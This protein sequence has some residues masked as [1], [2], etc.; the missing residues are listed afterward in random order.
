M[1]S[2][3]TSVNKLAANS[4]NMNLEPGDT[5][6]VV[7]AH[8]VPMVL[9]IIKTDPMAAKMAKVIFLNQDIHLNLRTATYQARWAEIRPGRPQV[10]E[11]SVQRDVEVEVQARL[12]RLRIDRSRRDHDWS[13]RHDDRRALVDDAPR[14]LD[15]APVLALFDI[16]AVFAAPVLVTPVIVVVG[17]GT[18]RKE[19][20]GT[21]DRGGQDGLPH[22]STHCS[23][24]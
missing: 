2:I 8:R 6:G 18:H 23:L 24:L 17:L 9:A 4:G 22:K 13:R 1:L 19:D 10:D 7:H 15:V 14:R 20:T 16:L 5:S 3:N 11:I 21:R 12:D